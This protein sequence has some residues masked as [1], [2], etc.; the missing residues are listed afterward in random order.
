MRLYL[1]QVFWLI[2]FLLPIMTFNPIFSGMPSFLAR[3]LRPLTT[4]SSLAAQPESLSARQTSF[5]PNAQKATVA[6]GCF[7]GV[8]HLFRR[9]FGNDKGLLDARVGYIGGGSKNTSTSPPTY[10]TVCSGT[11]GHAEALQITFDPDAVSYSQLLEFFFNMHD[12]TTPNRQ[13]YDTGTQYRSAIFT[14]DD[15]QMR[16][17]TNIRDRVA[18]H[19]WNKKPVVTEIVSVEDAGPWYDAEDYHQLYLSNNP[20]GYECVAHR[21]YGFRELPE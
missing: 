6:A 18:R 13:G 12:P 11:T 20:G 9:R 19:W 15:Q 1:A 17:A 10:R 2:A 16:I 7:W 8:E 14:H 5:P 4:S 3:L 21:D